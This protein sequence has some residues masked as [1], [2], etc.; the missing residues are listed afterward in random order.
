MSWCRKSVAAAVAFLVAAG[1]YAQSSSGEETPVTPEAA[2]NA[3]PQLPDAI[4]ARIGKFG[5]LV[6]IS[7]TV[8]QAQPVFDRIIGYDELH[9]PIWEKQER[10]RQIMERRKQAILKQFEEDKKTGK[11]HLPPGVKTDLE[12]WR[13]GNEKVRQEVARHGPITT[14]SFFRVGLTP[15]E[16]QRLMD[17]KTGVLVTADGRTVPA[18]KYREEQEADS[19]KVRVAVF[20]LAAPASAPA[21]QPVVKPSAATTYWQTQGAVQEK[22]VEEFFPDSPK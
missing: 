3:A 4:L 15:E 8:F 2:K 16:S 20:P 1:V 14:K 5:P 12:I 11:I 6:R 22:W 9:Q 18:W 13:E 19:L 7:P 17:G 10:L 21:A